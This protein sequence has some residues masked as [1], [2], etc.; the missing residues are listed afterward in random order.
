[1]AAKFGY[2]QK[3]IETMPQ[4]DLEALQLKMLKN[5][6]EKAYNK[7][8][9]YRKIFDEE[10]FK[11][12]SI[13]KLEDVTKVPFTEKKHLR[14]GYAWGFCTNRDDVVEVH[15]TSGTTGKPVPGFSTMKDID[16]WGDCNARILKACG[17]GKGDILQNSYG[18]GLPTGG[19]GFQYGCHKLGIPMIPIG[20][21]QTERQLMLMQDFG[22][23]AITMTPSFAAYVGRK[24]QSLGVDPAND[25]DV[26]VG[27]HG[28]EPWSEAQRTALQEMYGMDAYDEFGMTEF[29]GPGMAAECEAKNGLHA[30]G[31][32]FLMEIIDPETGEWVADGEQGEIVWTWLYSD[33][34]ALIRYK[35]R[36]IAKGTHE[37][38]D[39]GRTH[40]RFFGIIGRVDDSVSVSGFIVYPTQVED[41]LLPIKDLDANFFQIIVDRP[42]DVDVLSIRIEAASDAIANDTSK[43]P[44][45]VNLVRNRVKETCGVTPKK[46]EILAPETIDRKMSGEAK[47]ATG[48]VID[49]RGDIG[50]K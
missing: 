6:L 48:R 12:D 15:T 40:P 13:K 35:S 1:M 42:G 17:L 31:D 8:P 41:A 9:A 28:A 44:D 50:K 18:F 27:L 45:L 43:H 21:G 23:T 37:T 36:D 33:G 32:A 39:C 30:W 19:S 49:N 25:L 3:D 24:A 10:G 22:V 38:C 11:V 26:R 2:F 14:D 34:T 4:K 20:P 47:M 7:S 46:V 16:I 29:N 5:Q